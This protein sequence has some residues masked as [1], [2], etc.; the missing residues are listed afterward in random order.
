VVWPQLA[1]QAV[2]TQVVEQ[3]WPADIRPVD[4]PLVDKRSE[5]ES[6]AEQEEYMRVDTLAAENSRLGDKPV[7]RNLAVDNFEARNLAAG[8]PAVHSL[9]AHIPVAD[10]LV[11]GNPAEDNPAVGNPAARNLEEDSQPDIPV[12]LDSHNLADTGI[13]LVDK[14]N[15][16]APG[17][18]AAGSRVVVDFQKRACRSHDLTGWDWAAVLR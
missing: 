5:G 7:V 12:A 10:I 13:P 16:V 9:A 1:L 2:H 14:D 15:P 4:I 6:S 8:S 11:A 17:M 18:V 3:C